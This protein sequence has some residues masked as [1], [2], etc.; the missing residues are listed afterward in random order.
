MS[1]SELLEQIASLAGAINRHKNSG[2]SYNSDHVVVRGRGTYRGA[3]ARGRASIYRGSAVPHRNRTLVLNKPSASAQTLDS[4]A[5][6]A[7]PAEPLN[8]TFVKKRDRH[9]Q[10]INSS[11]YD[12]LAQARTKAIE[13]TRVAKAKLIEEKKMG[14]RAAREAL[15]AKRVGQLEQ[16]EINGVKY[17]VER[18]GSKLIRDT[19]EDTVASA[20]K[21][22]VVGGV[23][24]LRS[25]TG[26][27]WRKGVVKSKTRRMLK[28]IDQPCKYFT[29]TGSCARGLSCPYNHDPSH[30]AICPQYLHNKCQNP[31]CDL[32]HT[33]S[34]HN[35]PLCVHY[36]RG[37]CSN[38]QCKY[39]HMNVSPNANI[40][41]DFALNL[42][43]DAGDKC[44]K[45]HVFECPD[46]EE[47]GSC[48]RGPKKCKLPHIVRAKA[49]QVSES[50]DGILFTDDNV[51][52]NTELP[53]DV[54]QAVRE[55]MLQD[56]RQNQEA[57]DDDDNDSDDNDSEEEDDD[58]EQEEFDS[59]VVDQ[60]ESDS[61]VSDLDGEREFIRF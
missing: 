40:C 16:V 38:S 31:T 11:V 21:K 52:G 18:G 60:I 24:F 23:T 26:N 29:M 13:E 59:D 42:Y 15:R 36:Q 37:N 9:M 28:S 2:S 57:K 5:T 33:P 30:V 39:T 6:P 12:G 25:K 48:P 56:E 17:R 58:A 55:H 32:S 49:G 27:L 54:L 3:R 22:V 44:D 4:A 8:P 43:C 14:R 20:P 7:E 61:D 51:S 1:D 45:R 10:L 41:R 46:F 53:S 47:T 50:G 19:V 34:A 35:T